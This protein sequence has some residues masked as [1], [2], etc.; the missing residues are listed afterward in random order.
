MIC[1]R[2]LADIPD[3]ADFCPSCDLAMHPEVTGPVDPTKAKTQREPMSTMSLGFAFILV[4]LLATAVASPLAMTAH[5]SEKNITIPPYSHYA[6]RLSV[7]GLGLRDYSV[8]VPMSAPLS[9]VALYEMNEENY[10]LYTSGETYQTLR[11]VVLS[12]GVT[13]NS[14]EAG[15]MWVKYLVFSNATPMTV[16]VTVAYS[17]IP[18]FSF[19]VAIPIF[20]LGMVAFVIIAS[21]RK[22]SRIQQTSKLGHQ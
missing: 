5:S 20:S 2:C 11:L 15:V 4:L 21:T 10:K 16:T 9:G 22:R 13:V 6:V 12:S 19:Y 1:P 14:S 3:R 17:S 7:Y 18:L 8:E